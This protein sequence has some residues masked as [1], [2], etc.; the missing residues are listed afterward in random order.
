MD[1]YIRNPVRGL[2][3]LM[4]LRLNKLLYR[5]YGNCNTSLPKQTA[6]CPGLK[7][8]TGQFVT[9][10]LLYPRQANALHPISITQSQ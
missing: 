6:K 4:F 3:L 8:R 10:P 1:D 7:A 9:R 2:T 5:G